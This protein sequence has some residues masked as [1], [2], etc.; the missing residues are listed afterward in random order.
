MR[1]ADLGPTP[2]RMRSASISRPR[3]GEYF[4]VVA[5]RQNGISYSRFVAGL[6]AADVEVDRKILAELAVSDADA[7]AAL[8]EV[9]NQALASAGDAA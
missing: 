6:R 9:A 3:V 7:F 1:W 2:G 4:K 5:C 8:V